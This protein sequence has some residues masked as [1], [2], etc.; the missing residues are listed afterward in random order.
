MKSFA[1]HFIVIVISIVYLCASEHKRIHGVALAEGDINSEFLMHIAA[2]PQAAL[3]GCYQMI[4]IRFFLSRSPSISCAVCAAYSSSFWYQNSY[5]YW[6][7]WIWSFKFPLLDVLSE[8]ASSALF[9]GKLKVHSND[10]IQMLLIT[11]L[12]YEIL[13]FFL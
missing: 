10:F 5:G 3:C 12:A 1:Y 13:L 9:E 7:P 11:K 8:T 2:A 6:V 4:Y